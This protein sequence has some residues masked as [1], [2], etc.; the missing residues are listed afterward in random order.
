M[1]LNRADNSMQD[2]N[3]S[4]P[5]GKQPLILELTRTSAVAVIGDASGQRWIRHTETKVWYSIGENGC[6]VQI[7]MQRL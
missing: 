7:L 6:R 1:G 2:C 4:Q 3:Y 5:Q